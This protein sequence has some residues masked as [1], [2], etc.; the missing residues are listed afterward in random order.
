[1]GAKPR[2][3]G[4]EGRPRPGRK[5]TYKDLEK[6]PG[7]EPASLLKRLPNIYENNQS[8]ARYR[9]SEAVFAA[10]YRVNT[11]DENSRPTGNSCINYTNQDRSQAA[12]FAKRTRIFRQKRI[13]SG[14]KS[15]EYRSPRQ[16]HRDTGPIPPPTAYK[17][18]LEVVSGGESN[19]Q[20]PR[21]GGF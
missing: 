20:G 3:G 5:A 6:G 7:E 19:P 13:C 1:M 10:C 4:A 21:V 12:V 18:D 17:P 15:I 2:S 9:R 14:V 8:S 11:L 16:K